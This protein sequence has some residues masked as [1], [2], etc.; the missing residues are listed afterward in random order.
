MFW[1]GDMQIMGE[2]VYGDDIYQAY[3]ETTSVKQ[4]MRAAKVCREFP[5]GE[6]CPTLS[7]THHQILVGLPKEVQKAMLA[8]AE[9]EG[10]DTA[11]LRE[12]V[13]ELKKDLT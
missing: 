7:F 4:A 8:R 9:L 2:A 10:M 12:I 11:A 5:P 3:D 6:R 1:L 13:S